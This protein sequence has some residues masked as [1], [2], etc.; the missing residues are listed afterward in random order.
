M[1]KKKLKPFVGLPPKYKVGDWVELAYP[2]GK[3]APLAQILEDRGPLGQ[4]GEHLYHIRQLLWG[5]ETEV[6]T[7]AERH[8]RPAKAPVQNS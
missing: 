8:L 3:P 6:T 2:E 1:A 7:L 5:G 4:G